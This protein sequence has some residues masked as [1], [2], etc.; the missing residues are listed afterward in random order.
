MIG[1]YHNPTISSNFVTRNWLEAR[2]GRSKFDLRQSE[3]VRARAAYTQ[4]G[5]RFFKLD[6]R[7]T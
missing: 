5:Q 3:L 6:L 4:V 1:G 2:V 7:D